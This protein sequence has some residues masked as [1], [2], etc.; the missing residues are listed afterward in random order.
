MNLL[1][2]LAGLAMP[3]CGFAGAA[4]V[5][6]PIAMDFSRIERPATP[7]TALAAP[8]DFRPAPDLTTPVYAVVA[9]ALQTALREVA[10]AQA[11]VFPLAA[12]PERGQIFWVAR[13]ALFNFP[14]VIGAE[15]RAVG[16]ERSTLVLYS[17][18]IYGRSDFGANRERLLAWIGALDAK[19]GG[20][21]SPARQIH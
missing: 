9:P 20:A 17:R 21:G 8:A 18:S 7:N 3:A 12:Y 13:S 16:P 15:I 4:G 10:A 11:R 6:V 14:D 2:W 5:A 1:A 19:T